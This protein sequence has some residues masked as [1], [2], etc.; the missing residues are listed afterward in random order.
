[1][2]SRSKP[3][4]WEPTDALR[5]RSPERL[6]AE[7]ARYMVA[8]ERDVLVGL[9][10]YYDCAQRLDTDPVS[11]FDAA[12][13]DAGPSVRKLASAFARRSDVTLEAFGWK[14]DHDAQGPCYRPAG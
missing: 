11:L 10:P 7:L 13:R 5:A 1:M 2:A 6:L 3:I 4:C 8:A 14:L 12:G 9:A